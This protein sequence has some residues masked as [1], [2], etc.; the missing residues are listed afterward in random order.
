[1]EANS[2]LVVDGG[3]RS[4]AWE[5]SREEMSMPTA[6]SLD[7]GCECCECARVGMQSV[8]DWADRLAL[9]RVID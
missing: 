3:R 1:M 5:E 4:F 8:L 7:K 6:L 9:C 2:F